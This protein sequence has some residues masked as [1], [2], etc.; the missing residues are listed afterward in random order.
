[1]GY[2]HWSDCATNRAP[3]FK[4]KPCDC[5]GLN[6]AAYDRYVRITSLVP[7]PR[8]LAAFIED[9]ILP[10]AVEAEQT[11]WAGIATVAPSPD[12]PSSHDGVPVFGDTSRVDLDNASKPAVSNTEALTRHQRIARNVPPH[13]DTPDSDEPEC[14]TRNDGVTNA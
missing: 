12:L 2:N 10:S 14:S 4:T 7:T 3:A 9:G 6:L 13:K 8:S 11:P 1:M 5:G